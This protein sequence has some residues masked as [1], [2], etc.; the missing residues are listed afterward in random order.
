MVKLTVIQKR[1]IAAI[2]IIHTIGL[3][4]IISPYQDIFIQL[5]SLNLVVSAILILPSFKDKKLI[6]SFITVFFL[7]YLLEYIGVSSGLIFGEYHYGKGLF[8]LIYGV[9]LV[10][11]VNWWMLCYGAIELTRSFKANKIVHLLLATLVLTLVDFIMEQVA[12]KLDYWHWENNNIPIQNY[13]A[14]SFFGAIF[15]SM[16]KV[17]IGDSKPN[18][19]A[20]FL[21]LTQIIF[22]IL[23][24]TLL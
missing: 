23:L 16:L 11:G 10:I 24:F 5:S 2:G 14:W 17:Q 12:P 1:K 21:I 15:I 18:S 9:P 6:I 19:V 3:L 22:F 4:G 13:L 7:G 20:P 8:P